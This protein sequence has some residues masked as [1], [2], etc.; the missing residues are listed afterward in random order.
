M[1]SL[2]RTSAR[3]VEEARL[4]RASSWDELVDGFHWRIP[5]ELN[6]AEATVERHRGSGRVALVHD[7]GREVREVTFDELSS[8]SSRLANALAGLGTRRGDRVAILLPQRPEVAITHL[9]A[10]K[11]AAVS[12]PLTTLFGPRALV[13][14]LGVA[15]PTVVVCARDSVEMLREEVVHELEAPPQ[16]LVVDEDDTS[17]PTGT[18]SF[19]GAV[20]DASSRCETATT[21]ADDPAFLSFTSG[22]TGP[23]KGALHAHRCLLGHLPGFQVSHDL[24]PRSGDR[25]WTPA[26]WAWIGGFMNVLFTSLSFGLTVVSAP[27]RF[28]PVEA[29]EIAARHG[30]RN[31]FLPPTALRLMRQAHGEA[32]PATTFRTIGSGGESLGADTLAWARER[33]GCAINEFYGQTEA[34][35]VVS[36]CAALFD[37]RPGSMGRV[38]PGHVVEV[39]DDA[40]QPVEPGEL[41]EICVREGTP[42]GFLGYFEDEAAT[43]AKVVNGW[44]RTGDTATRDVDGHVWFRARRD[45]VITS[46][47]YRV[48]PGEIEECLGRHPA[49]RLAAAVGVPDPIRTEVVKAFVELKPGVEPGERLEQELRDFVRSELAA[50][51]YPRIVEFVDEIPLTATGKIRRAELRARDRRV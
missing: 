7:D 30:V 31:A 47:G 36:N 12:V 19:A 14:R 3:A 50:Y 27:R 33:L 18:L 28:D 1:G 41:G 6:M 46:A 37:A 40:L 35:L 20:A 22:T 43:A 34:N 15:R 17:A 45:D 42:T 25:F 11:L 10:W 38:V 48:G 39:L 16:L 51:L 8:D 49:V 9:A 32:T 26:D 24:A 13:H 21:A 5:A 4:P 23:A 44:I 29:W 2:T